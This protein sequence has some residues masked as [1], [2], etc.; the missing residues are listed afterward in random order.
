MQDC[1]WFH[2]LMDQIMPFADVDCRVP[3]NQQAELLFN[4]FGGGFSCKYRK[5]RADFH[6]KCV[7]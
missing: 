6:F 3:P 4:I 1:M 7:K 2:G 5:P